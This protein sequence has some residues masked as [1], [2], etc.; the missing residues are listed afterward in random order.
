MSNKDGVVKKIEV[1]L[2]HENLRIIIEDARKNPVINSELAAIKEIIESI[3]FSFA[4]SDDIRIIEK[5]ALSIMA[6][7]GC[8]L[9]SGLHHLRQN[10]DIDV[11][12]YF[13]GYIFEPEFY[14][15]EEFREYIK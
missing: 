6:S 9:K 10:E 7:V 2:L 13:M 12:R 1:Q 5:T 11:T 15:E 8:M 3:D 4:D 14:D